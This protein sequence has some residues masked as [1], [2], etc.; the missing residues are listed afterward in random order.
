MP[1]FLCKCCQRAPVLFEF[2][3]EQAC[4]CTVL[5]VLCLHTDLVPGSLSPT[6]AG[7]WHDFP[8][9]PQA[10]GVSV[11]TNRWAHT[12]SP[13]PR[14]PPH[15]RRM[16]PLQHRPHRVLEL[17][18]V[19]TAGRGSH[20]SPSGFNH[21]VHPNTLCCHRCDIVCNGSALGLHTSEF[22]DSILR[23]MCSKRKETTE[24]QPCLA[25]LTAVH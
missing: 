15:D 10:S 25:T 22:V 9:V 21:I 23:R 18:R 11:S 20:R 13:S 7:S 17:R 14:G 6:R 3:L 24:R 12:T 8:A 19:A 4:G 16:P 5:F 2:L 1:G